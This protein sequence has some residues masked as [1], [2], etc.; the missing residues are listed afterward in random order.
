MKPN[1]VILQTVT[2]IV[3]FIILTFAIYLFLAGH[4]EPGGGFIGGLVIASALTLLY[5]AF[6]IETVREG[7]PVDFKVVA[8][9]GV[10]IAVATGMGSILFDQPFLSQA[11]GYFNLPIFGKTELA[12]AVLFDLGVALAVVGTGV[13]IILSISR[14]A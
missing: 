12:T 10:F 2:K 7:L 1:D 11:F 6:D 9:V 5:L 14:D 3:T 4:H 13:T 8:A